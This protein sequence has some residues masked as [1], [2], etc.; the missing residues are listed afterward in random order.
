MK[1]ELIK[2]STPTN[3]ILGDKG[4]FSITYWV[5]VDESYAPPS[6]HFAFWHEAQEYFDQIVV[7]GLPKETHEILKSVTI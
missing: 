7:D 6:K 4:A 2:Q 1:L 3:L 5:K